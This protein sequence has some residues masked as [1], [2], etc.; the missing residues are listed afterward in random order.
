M[1][2]VFGERRVV[3][4]IYPPF[5]R[6]GFFFTGV[7]SGGGFS[8]PGLISSAIVVLRLFEI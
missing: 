7:E 3:G 8:C 2:L 4:H 1:T 5:H 6:D